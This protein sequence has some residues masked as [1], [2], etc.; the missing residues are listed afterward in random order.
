[1]NFTV[2]TVLKTL[3]T[4]GAASSALTKWWKKARGDSRS[5]IGELKDNLIY[6]DLVSNGEV[7][8]ADVIEKLSVSE[9]KRLAKEGFNFNSL[10][11]KKITK[12]PS[13]GGTDLASWRARETADLVESIYDKI[14]DLKIRYPL[15]KRNK[16][17]RWNI[18]VYNI[19]KRIWLLL[20]HVRG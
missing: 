15:V 5:L 20:K 8:L 11:K 19:R 2:P 10:K 4:A 1:M 12:Y 16:K 3:S 7:D 6:L 17:Y 9:Y 18:R 14:N 13:L